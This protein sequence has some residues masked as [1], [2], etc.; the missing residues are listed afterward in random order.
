MSDLKFKKKEY[1]TRAEAS[2]RLT[3]IAKALRSSEK[4]ELEH[5]GE[6][7]ELELDVPDKVLLEFEVEIADGETELELEIKW[8]PFTSPT[9][10]PG[11]DA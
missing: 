5:D 9:A 10:S 4:L 3:E 11:P 2:A 8:A 1:L 6:E 7:I